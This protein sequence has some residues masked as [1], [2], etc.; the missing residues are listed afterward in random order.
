VSSNLTAPTILPSNSF[1]AVISKGNTG[2]TKVV[3]EERGSTGGIAPMQILCIDDESLLRELREMLKRFPKN[4]SGGLL[5]SCFQK[6][7][8]ES[9]FPMQ[10]GCVQE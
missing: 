2:I 4:L 6:T 1:A 3:E 9:F 10:K 7:V 8:L 5:K